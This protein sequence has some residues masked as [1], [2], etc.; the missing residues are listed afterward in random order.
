MAESSIISS[1]MS[2]SLVHLSH[3]HPL[4]GP[5]IGKHGEM[6]EMCFF[7]LW[8]S[9]YRTNTNEEFIT[10]LRAECSDSMFSKVSLVRPSFS[11]V[12]YLCPIPSKRAEES[13]SSLWENTGFCSTPVVDGYIFQGRRWMWLRCQHLASLDYRDCGSSRWC[14][15]Q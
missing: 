7:S 5:P 14:H 13:A 12:P 3:H 9:V 8:A 6:Y 11:T 15:S 2:Y 4:S 1:L 10:H